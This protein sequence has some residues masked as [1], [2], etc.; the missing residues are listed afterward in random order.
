[1]PYGGTVPRV[2]LSLS[3]PHYNS[4]T[5][6]V[7]ATNSSGLLELPEVNRMACIGAATEM[8][9]ACSLDGWSVGGNYAPLRV[10]VPQC[11]A[12]VVHRPLNGILEP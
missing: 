5:H 12:L 6:S 3:P 8:G 7:S 1:V 4:L 2:P 10:L 9:P 11:T